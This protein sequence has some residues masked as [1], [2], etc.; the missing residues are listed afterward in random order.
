MLTNLLPNVGHF[1]QE[2]APGEISEA[3]KLWVLG[4]GGGTVVYL[5]QMTI[6]IWISG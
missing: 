1:I 4:D 3:N 5:L 2:A 6:H